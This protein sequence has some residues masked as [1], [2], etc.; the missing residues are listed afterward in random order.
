MC[1]ICFWYHQKISKLIFEGRLI[2]ATVFVW[3][4]SGRSSWKIKIRGTAR[5]SAS[6]RSSELVSWET[7]RSG[8]GRRCRRWRRTASNNLSPAFWTNMAS[9]TFLGTKKIV[10]KLW[11][12]ASIFWLDQFSLVLA[13]WLNFISKVSFQLRFLNFRVKVYFAYRDLSPHRPFQELTYYYLWYYTHLYDWKYILWL[14]SLWW[15]QWIYLIVLLEHQSTKL[16]ICTWELKYNRR[17]PSNTRFS[18]FICTWRI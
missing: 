17:I 2:S 9:R 7:R 1:V 6:W 15:L 4:W 5:R 8:T 18:A 14:L 10:S 16:H 11:R 3:R 12:I 13:C